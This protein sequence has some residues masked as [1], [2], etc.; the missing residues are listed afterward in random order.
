MAIRVNG[1]LLAPS[2]LHLAAALL[3]GATL[4][5]GCGNGVGSAVSPTTQ[6]ASTA[7]CTVYSTYGV[8]DDP[9]VDMSFGHTEASNPFDPPPTA[10]MAPR[11][12]GSRAV[13]VVSAA[14]HPQGT[15]VGAFHVLYSAPGSGPM[16]FGDPHG[17]WTVNNG[18]AV[19]LVEYRV[20][21]HGQVC[22]L[23]T[24][25]HATAT[26]A[27]D[28][29]R[30]VRQS[31]FLVMPGYD[32]TVT[33]AA[34]ARRLYAALWA[35]GPQ[36]PPVPT[37]SCPVSSGTRWILTFLDS[38]AT[39]LTVT[40][41]AQGCHEMTLSNGTWAE[42]VAPSAEPFWAALDEA[43]ALPDSQVRPHLCGPGSAD[44]CYH[45]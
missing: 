35:L 22:T 33:D 19:W 9:T 12:P 14:D 3:G 28:A 10:S 31:G 44:N 20:G 25:S 16:R 13:E 2:R 39:V 1:H 24:S 32:R 27:V 38:G 23:P 45:E 7:A 4:V 40:L 21:L 30:L 5:A 11:M 37:S 17:S 43:A 26:T 29:V 8:A 34:T 15:L 18:D 41:D 42:A 6:L 36:P